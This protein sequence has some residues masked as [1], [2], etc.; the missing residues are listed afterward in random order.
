MERLSLRDLGQ[1]ADLDYTHLSK[2]EAGR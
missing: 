2:V 1:R